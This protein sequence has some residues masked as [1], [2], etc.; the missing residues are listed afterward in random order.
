M[1]DFQRDILKIVVDKALLAV[2]AMLFGFYLS[3]LLENYRSKKS[4]DLFVWQQRIDAYRKA[5]ALAH[6][7]STRLY[8][9]Y[10]AFEA[11]AEKGPADPS[12]TDQEPI[13]EWCDFSQRFSIEFP[14]LMPF[15]TYDSANL[16]INY[17]RQIRGIEDLLKG[18]PLEQ[19]LPT[20]EEIGDAAA[21]F[22]V[23]LSHMISMG[24]TYDPK[25]C[26]DAGESANHGLE[27]T[28]Y[29]GPSG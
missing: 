10:E 21:L 13:L 12:D 23:K 2:I 27:G 9:A 8:H 11:M 5:A 28:A 22:C 7:Y 6:E 26:P 3:R 20:K 15:F 16:A 4:Y 18:K 29:S 14:S 1:D 24:E 17:M 19:P 25:K